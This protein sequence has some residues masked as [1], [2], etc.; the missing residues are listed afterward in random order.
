L[1]E[2]LAAEDGHR[3]K[4]TGNEK[5]DVPLHPSGELGKGHDYFIDSHHIDEMGF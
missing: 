2:S 1:L 5:E 4:K 3:K